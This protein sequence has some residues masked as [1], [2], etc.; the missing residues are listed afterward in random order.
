MRQFD[1][2]ATT[3]VD[4]PL[5]PYLVILQSDLLTDL[6]TRLAAPFL[7]PERFQPIRHL[8]PVFA[9]AGGRW[10]MATQMMAAVPRAELGGEVVT[11]LAHERDAIIRAIDFLLSGV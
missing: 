2:V 4:R 11:S 8:N 6:A 9:F 1:V 5:V 10:M 3:A 7:A